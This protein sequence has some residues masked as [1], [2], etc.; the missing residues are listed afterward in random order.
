MVSVSWNNIRQLNGSQNAGFEELCTQLARI[1][2][3]HDAKFTRTG[4][5]DAGVEGYCVLQN[6][7]EWGWQAKYFFSLD[8]SQLAQ[9]D[10]SVKTAL[11]KHP[12]L[13]RY[14][15][16]VPID[17]A[18]ARIPGRTSAM[19]RWNQHVQ[20]WVGWAQQRKMQVQFMWWGASEL[21]ERL[22]QPQQI[23]RLFYWFGNHG[24]DRHWFHERLTE[25]I[26]AAGPRYN[27]QHHVELDIAKSL[28]DFARTIDSFNR[29]KS[30]AIDVRQRA[31]YLRHP[32]A[33]DHQPLDIPVLQP[34]LVTVSSVLDEFRALEF[35]PAGEL[36]VQ[37]IQQALAGAIRIANETQPTIAELQREYESQRDNG[38]ELP[39]HQRDPYS[40]VTRDLS[41]LERELESVGY[42]LRQTS[43]VSNKRLMILKGSAG[44]G[45][46]HLMCD[47]ARRRIDAGAPV[48]LLMGQ[49]FTDT[50][51]PWRQMLEQVGMHG[52]TPDTFV[53]ALEAAAQSANSRALLMID[54]VNEGRGRD[55]WLSHLAAFLSR[56]QQSQ[57]IATILSVRSTYE[58]AI[59]PEHIGRRA[60]S[61]THFGFRGH[62][63]E[64]TRIFFEHHGIEFH[65]TPILYPEFANPLYLK[66]ICRVLQSTGQTR[67][68]GGR[69]GIT[70]VLD[71]FID[72]TNEQ[73]AGRLDYDPRNN[74]VSLAL[75]R[76]A[77]RFLETGDHWLIR[78][79]AAR[80]VNDVLPGRNF[81]RSLYRGMVDEGILLEDMRETR[82]GDSREIVTI[83]FER[84][85][86]HIVAEVIMQQHL[87]KNRVSRMF[88]SLPRWWRDRARGLP[89]LF[90]HKATGWIDRS[91]SLVNIAEGRRFVPQGV[92]EALCIQAPERTGR[93]L[94]RITPQFQYQWR[95]GGAFLESL[96]WRELA[97]FSEETRVVLNELT[98]NRRMHSDPKDTLITVS[99]IPGH[100]FNAEFLDRRLRQDNMPDRDTWWST[101]LHRAWGDEG[102]VDRL[103]EWAF[104]ISPGDTVDGEVVDLAATTLGWMLTT[105]QRFLRDRAT[106]GLVALLTGRLASLDRFVNRFADVDDPY[107]VERI[108]AAAYGVAMRSNDATGVGRVAQSVYRHVF[109]GG[110]PPAHLL[111]RDYARGVIERAAYLGAAGDL[112]LDLVRPPY[113]SAFPE[114]PDEQLTK[115]LILKME[116]S[117]GG[118][119]DRS[120]WD[121]I[122]FS[123]QH[124]D[125]ARYI[126][127]TNSTDTSRHWLSIGIEQ[128]QWR[129]ADELEQLLIPR[130]N[131]IERNAW[132]EYLEACQSV[133]PPQ[134]DFLSAED[135]HG[136]PVQQDGDTSEPPI[137]SYFQ[138]S[139]RLSIHRADSSDVDDAYCRFVATLSE[140]NWDEWSSRHEIR[141]GFNT[142]AIQR[143]ILQRVVSLGWTARRFG[144][145]DSS[146]SFAGNDLRGTRK[147]ER[148]G[149]KYQWIAYHEI[150]AFTA[151]NHQY[152]EKWENVHD[153]QG[154]WQ[155]GRRDIDPSTIVNPCLSAGE[156][157]GS[158]RPTWWAPL[159][160]DNWQVELPISTW[161]ANASDVPELDRGLLIT[162]PSD[163]NTRW[164]NAYCFQVRSEP[165]PPDIREYDV[166]RKEIWTRSIAFLVPRGKADD[167]VEWVL[168]GAY[169]DEHWPQSIPDF[170]GGDSAFLGEYAWG[171]AF[172]QLTNS[173]RLNEHE[174]CHPPG[175]ESAMAYGLAAHCSTAGSE[176]DCSAD[177][178]AI[179]TLHLP[180]HLVV[181]GCRLT[182]TGVG[183]DYVDVS[184][185]MAAFDPS[186]HQLGPN[187]LLLRLD[188]LEGYLSEYDLEMCWA[189]TGE[190][191]STGTFGQPYGWLKFQGA[192]V[193][194]NGNPVGKSKSLHNSPSG[195]SQNVRI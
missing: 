21:V 11:A 179:S 173:G 22:S 23:G 126:L 87:D 154:P 8:P 177:E 136:D 68:P 67:L 158:R 42:E 74:L 113:Q 139:K 2:T 75:R 97:A 168:T 31:L 175:S 52:E 88:E 16:C 189:V 61:V 62:E 147:P 77:E 140:E 127:G 84:F 1:E 72:V 135:D 63:Y 19:D 145:F 56:I 25:A 187:A 117:V 103:V 45:K 10:D 92:I 121:A 64:A 55:I 86:D 195:P 53:G 102:P 160:Y 156:T 17:R 183:A 13:K 141:P 167:F 15:V 178:D 165:T 134:I 38:E 106:K 57:W 186:A 70:T 151:D 12:N 150:L 54:A 124:W 122:P 163:T 43:G 123:V 49:R 39:Q 185:K 48:V 99:T 94:V 138:T 181:R 164:V 65:S 78:Q 36:E 155:V 149:K 171:P 20:K 91:N 182:W 105:P 82:N 96:V 176:Y 73:L 137:D 90:G 192:Y 109:A 148:M 110:T 7:D 44:T 60:T 184:S 153:Y 144:V 51:D 128:E 143:Y 80:V 180:S 170:G 190:K 41:G 114:I 6:G 93:E 131:G 152:H 37:P 161:T 172:D 118:D 125:F 133:P 59:I 157:S 89:H 129:S 71:S 34:L 166:E 83:A 101:Y 174:W 35:D 142:Q 50:G 130:F 79:D 191:Q 69:Q 111:L 104:N 58:G 3:P 30:L 4:N 188:L 98:A 100:P 85:A 27:P 107:V 32:R 5:P 119:A 81:S 169:S 162:D 26:G 29:I 112:D 9:I 46:T 116:Q 132:E 33:N 24:F 115:D 108:Y 66:T 193:L 146:L 28:E 76:L 14:Y 194:R 159:E 18:D 40:R 120:A 47:F 95:I